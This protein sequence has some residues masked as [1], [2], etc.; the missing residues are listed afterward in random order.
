M[1]EI[2]Y[3]YRNWAAMSDPALAKH[4]GAFV[5]HYR[6]EQNKTQEI[7]AKEAGMSRSTL[8][9]LERGES[10]TLS[11]LIQALRALD[12][13]YVL[14]AFSIPKTISPMMVA[15]MELKKRKRARGKKNTPPH[16]SDW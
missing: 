14:D 12:K 9:L 6:V 15:E 3:I 1:S 10:V 5:K 11:T 4:I 13:L 8:S 16:T 2:S 7:L